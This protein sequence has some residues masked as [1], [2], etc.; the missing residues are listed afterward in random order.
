MNMFPCTNISLKTRMV[1]TWVT[2]CACDCKVES[3]Q[4]RQKNLEITSRSC[5]TNQAH[6]TPKLFVF[7]SWLPVW[8]NK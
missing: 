6:L 2:F 8:L 4:T 7:Y 5:F 1:G 3:N